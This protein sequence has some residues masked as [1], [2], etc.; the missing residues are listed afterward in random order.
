MK[1]YEYDVVIV[2]AR[3]AGATLATFLARAGTR[4]LLLD[5]D[6]MPSDHVLSTLSISPPGMDVLDEVGVGTAVRAVAPPSHVFRMG[7]DGQFL[8]LKLPEHRPAYGPRRKRLDSLL[9]QAAIGAGARFLDRARVTS[10]I[11]E[12]GRVRGVRAIISDRERTFTA[13]LVV[14]ADGRRSTVAKLTGAEE[15]LGYDAPRATYWGYWDAPR[16]WKTDPAYRFDAY[17]G[18][19]GSDIRFIFQTDHDQLLIGSTLP[20][21]SVGMGQVE[22]RRALRAALESDAITFAL[23]RGSRPIGKVCGTIKERFFFR[24][25]VGSGWALVGDAGH[26]KEFLLG[27]GI[28][29][30]LL[31]ARSLAAAIGDGTDA[32]LSRWWRARDVAALPLY[33]IGQIVGAAARPVELQRILFSELAHEPALVARM[34][35][36]MERQLSP[37]EALPVPRVVSW[38]TAAALRGR[39]RVVA[40]MLGIGRRALAMDREM[41]ARCNLLLEAQTLP[42]ARDAA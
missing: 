4:V 16:F 25:A 9:Q 21:G 5:K 23:I 30:A 8:D 3:C 37:F 10:L 18:S 20:I 17:F 31:Q 12:D 36:I 14:G 13:R 7:I 28:T 11:Q 2:G 26:H 29:E 42:L 40:E 39:W 1:E 22:P 15:Y 33:F 41:R 19:V 32:T 6:A 35:A 34:V 38:I 27:D 24:R